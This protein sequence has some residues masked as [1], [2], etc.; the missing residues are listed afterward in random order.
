MKKVLLLCN[1]KKESDETFK[2]CGFKT[3]KYKL[4]SL[5][6]GK[7]ITWKNLKRRVYFWFIL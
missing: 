3:R 4:F 1:L 6:E 2:W 7:K 5:K